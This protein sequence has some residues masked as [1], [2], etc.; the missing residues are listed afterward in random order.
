MLTD[1][2]IIGIDIKSIFAQKIERNES[3]IGVLKVE[4][5]EEGERWKWY[6][7]ERFD[8]EH[9][10]G[11]SHAL[12]ARNPNNYSRLIEKGISKRIIKYFTFQIWNGIATD[13]KTTESNQR[14]I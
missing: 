14:Y 5:K 3:P 11:T 8:G 6:N 2:V 10:E 7:G 9:Q 12:E 1:F 4:S 13:R